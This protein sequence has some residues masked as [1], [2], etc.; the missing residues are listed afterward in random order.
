ME[1]E[2]DVEQYLKKQIKKNGG[3]SLKFTSTEKG[4]PDQTI[5]LPSGRTVYVE[6][7]KHNGVLSP[8]QIKM[9]KTF[10][11]LNQTVFTAFSKKEVDTI[12][13]DLQKEGEF[14]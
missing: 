8:S 3:K 10:R 11:K 9:H 7:K 13:K 2:K 12:I 4:V 14:D 1:L 6:T 5:L